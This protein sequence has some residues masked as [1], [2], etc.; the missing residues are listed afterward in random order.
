MNT[1]K[2]TDRGGGSP[3]LEEALVDRL[4]QLEWPRP[5]T[6]VKQ[7]CLD[8]IVARMSDMKRE[9]GNE[10][11]AFKGRV[12]GRAERHALTRYAAALGHRQPFSPSNRPVRV[13]TV[14][15]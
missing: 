3:D 8:D 9:D 13:A 6:E 12:S 7:R 10:R 4:R 5:T 14:L 15:W 2:G 1:D 11:L